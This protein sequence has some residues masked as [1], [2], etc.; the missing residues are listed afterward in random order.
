MHFSEERNESLKC[1]KQKIMKKNQAK[2]KRA[3]K[4]CEAKIF[5]SFVKGMISPG[6]QYEGR[7]TVKEAETKERERVTSFNAVEEARKTWNLGQSLGLLSKISE[8]SMIKQLV[9]ME[10]QN[11]GTYKKARRKRKSR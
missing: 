8:E 1:S 7:D 6:V 2:G 4:K 9:E 11:M 10:N 3:K 5:K